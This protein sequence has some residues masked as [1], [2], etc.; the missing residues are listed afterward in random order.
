MG[1]KSK[2]LWNTVQSQMEAIKNDYPRCEELTDYFKDT[3]GDF[4]DAP[5]LSKKR[6][7]IYGQMVSVSLKL[8]PFAEDMVNRIRIVGKHFDVFDTFMNEKKAARRDDWTS[9]KKKSLEDYLNKMAAAKPK[10]EDIRR[11]CNPIPQ[12]V[13]DALAHCKQA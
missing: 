5:L 10:L 11:L 6:K 9:L 8:L 3:L 12:Y 4:L 13:T 1:T 2:K 7:D